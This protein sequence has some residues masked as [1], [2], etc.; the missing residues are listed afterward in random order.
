MPQYH[1]SRDA[2][3][4]LLEIW[5]Y[6]AVDNFRAADRL[7]D[8]IQDAFE[9]LAQFPGM[10]RAR[11]ELATDLR[12]FPIGSYVIFYKITSTGVEIHRV[13]HGARDIQR[14]I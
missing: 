12:S 2:K 11:T 9:K 3:T 14:L 7:F 13:F 8:K 1:L 5:G 10:G 6:I 4:D